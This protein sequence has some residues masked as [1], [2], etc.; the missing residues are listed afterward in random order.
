MSGP[1]TTTYHSLNI[2]TFDHDLA[3]IE[4]PHLIASLD[5]PVF[6]PFLPI[7]QLLLVTS[8]KTYGSRPHIMH[9][10]RSA[11]SSPA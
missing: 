7:M 4:R 11:L 3:E 9:S 6:E 10:A 1:K 2:N 8:T 5:L